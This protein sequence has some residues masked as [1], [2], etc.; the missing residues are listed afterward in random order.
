MDFN[1]SVREAKL[2]FDMYISFGRKEHLIKAY[3]ADYEYTTF[4]CIEHSI[5]FLHKD[6]VRKALEKKSAA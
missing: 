2:Y 4:L 6:C 1:Y 5:Y 3:K